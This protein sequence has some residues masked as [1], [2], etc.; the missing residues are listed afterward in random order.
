MALERRSPKVTVKT[1]AGAANDLVDVAAN[2]ADIGEHA[3]VESVEGVDGLVAALPLAE[4][5]ED[6]FHGSGSLPDAGL[7]EGRLR[8]EMA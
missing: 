6:V 7:P 2:H 5:S 4:R 8:N 3:V 1:L